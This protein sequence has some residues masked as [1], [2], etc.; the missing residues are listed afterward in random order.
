M[1]CWRSAAIRGDTGTDDKKVE[2]LLAKIVKQARDQIAI[3]Y[4]DCGYYFEGHQCGRI[5]SNTGL[6][7]FVLA[8][9]VAAGKDLVAKKD[10]ARWLAA[11][12]N[13]EFALNPDGKFTNPQ[14]GMYC[15]D[16]PRGGMWSENGDFAQGFAICPPEYV[17]ALKWVYDRQVESGNE[18]TF[19]ILEYPGRR[20]SHWRTGRWR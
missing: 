11:K 1:G 5:S 9:R 12:W 10:N 7:P 8:Y 4:G 16:F 20:C 2:E 17:P 18:K 19:D 14:R 6:V 3:G 13:Y 15:R